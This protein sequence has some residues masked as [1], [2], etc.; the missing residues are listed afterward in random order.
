M[1]SPRATLLSAI[2]DALKRITRGNG[3]ITD[4]GQTVT[5]EPAPVAGEA[6]SEFI[7]VVWARQERAN[8]TA[9][10]RTHRATT[11][12]V[13]AKV[14]ARMSNAQARLDDITTDIETA[15][16]DQQFRFPVG[17]QFPQYQSAEPLMPQQSTTGWIGV[18]IA[19]ASH[20]P[21]RRPAA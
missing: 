11:V 21:I 14:A 6:E 15:M 13:I 17:Y 12:Q 4:A 2:E 8:D 19:Y 10:T 1:T 7:T 20:I 18:S 5:R 3:Y 9:L 16:A